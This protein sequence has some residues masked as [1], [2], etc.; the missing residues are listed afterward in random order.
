MKPQ[1]VYFESNGAVLSGLLYQPERA[2]PWPAAV[3]AGSWTSVKEQ[4]PATYAQALASLGYAALCFDFRGWGASSGE[5][6][7]LED[8]QRKIADIHAALGFMKARADIDTDNIALLGICASAGYMTHV[9]AQSDVPH[10]LCLIAPWL[11]DRG[12][13]LETYGGEAGVEA[14]MSAARNA[15]ASDG[16]VIEAASASNPGALMYQ[17]PYYTEPGR[18][19]I[20]Q[21]DNLFDVRSWAPWLSFDGIAAAEGITIPSCIVHSKAAAIPHGVTRFVSRLPRFAQVA[22]LEDV[23]QF[24]FYDRPDVVAEATRMVVA[25]L[26]AHRRTS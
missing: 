6:R 4:M 18:G 3:V 20:Q 15:E 22:W 2:G 9:A 10:A 26:D 5:P 1:H 16:V 23:S 11:H 17:V 24:D 19:L 7:Y 12:I 25:H 21:Y 8:P 13:V 14:L